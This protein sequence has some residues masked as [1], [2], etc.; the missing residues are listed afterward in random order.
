MKKILVA[1][2]LV[3]NISIVSNAGDVFESVEHHYA[4]SD[5]V[6]IHYVTKGEGPVLV[7]LH[8]FPDFWY[9]WRYQIEELSKNFKVAA[10]DL[11]GYNKSAAPKG[12]SNYAMPLLMKDVIAV[13]DD[14]QVE[15]ATLVANDWGGAIAWQVATFYP[16]RVERLVACNIPHP[17]GISSYLA[18]NPSTGQ[19]AQDFKKENA[20]ESLTAEGLTSLHTGLSNLE[21]KRYIDAFERSSFEGMLNYYKANYPAPP[22]TGA[23]ATA[24]PAPA[25]RKVKAPVLII[26]GT[27]DKA[28]PPGMLNNTWD[29]VDNDV[30]MLTIKDAGHFVQ[31][32]AHEKVN[33]MI[34]LWLREGP[35][36]N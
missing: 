17:A 16:N 32:E 24:S 11:R 10:V 3:L 1:F 33:R 18:K 4:D 21:R 8:G 20:H 23:P 26:Y 14:L 12:V 28:L 2:A 19:Y 27:Q 9:T 35:V 25:V 15:K 22:P 34:K 29:Y 30:T 6:K 5:G 36:E 7:M 13:I 31:Q